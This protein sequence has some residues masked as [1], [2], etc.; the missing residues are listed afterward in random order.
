MGECPCQGGLPQPGDCDPEELKN[1]LCM[2]ECGPCCACPASCIG[3]TT[4]QLRLRLVLRFHGAAGKGKGWGVHA[5]ENIAAGAFV[6]EYAGEY[7]T[8]EEARRRLR[9]YD[10]WRAHR[11]GH[12]LLVV[13]AVLPSG[14]AYL[15]INIDAT[16]KGNVARFINHCCGGG[17]LVPVIVRRQGDVLPKVALFASTSI[18]AGQELTFEYAETVDSSQEDLSSGSGVQ[19][20]QPPLGGQIG[21]ACCCGSL[22]C[23]G[24]LPRLQDV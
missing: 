16:R 24:L 9:E 14:G 3:R 21:R 13:R 20:L 6:C 22:A 17:N 4:Q 18:Q 1:L 15:R 12:A 5:Q 23:T 2:F 19:G 10:E 7:V 8:T 11:P